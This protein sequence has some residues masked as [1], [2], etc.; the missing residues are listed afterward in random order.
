M[1]LE[2]PWGDGA[3]AAR[4]GGSLA[5]LAVVAVMVRRVWRRTT[6]RQDRL[7]LRLQK[8]LTA[9]YVLVLGFAAMYAVTAT[10]SPEQFAGLA[11]RTDALYFSVATIGTVGFG[12]VHAAGTLAR[13]MV[14]VQ[15]LFNLI[16]L[17]TALRVLSA[18]T[19]S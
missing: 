16:Y 8:L 7:Y 12:D 3:A 17:G 6:T 15:M 14:T 9:L 2:A 18:R 5:A 10:A 11:N 19:A 1:P 13:V 4:L